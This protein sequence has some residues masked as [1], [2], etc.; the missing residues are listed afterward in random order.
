M[1]HFEDIEVNGTT[2]RVNLLDDNNE[3]PWENSDCHGVVSAWERRS[4][5]PGEL[6]LCEDRGSSRFYDFKASM[7]LAKRDGWGCK[8]S[9]GLTKGEVLAFAVQ[10]DYDFLRR[11][12]AGDWRYVCVEVYPLTEDGDELKSKADYMGGV[13][14]SD[15]NYLHEVAMQMIGEME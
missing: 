1:N 15:R 11:W 6:V 13:E 14:D 2:Y 5:H 8:D 4:K 7:A 3:P 10:A 9:E 12:C